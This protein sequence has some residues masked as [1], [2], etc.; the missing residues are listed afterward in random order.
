MKVAYKIVNRNTG[1]WQRQRMIVT[2][3][4]IAVGDNDILTGLVFKWMFGACEPSWL[5]IQ[6]RVCKGFIPGVYADSESNWT[7]AISTAF[8]KRWPA[9]TPEIAAW[10]RGEFGQ[11]A[12]G[13]IVWDDPKV[14]F[15]HDATLM[16]RP[17][18]ACNQSKV[19]V[20][21]APIPQ[22]AIDGTAISLTWEQARYLDVLIKHGDWMSD[23][24]YRRDHGSENDRPDRWRKALSPIVQTS[25]ET[26][27]KKGS[28]WKMA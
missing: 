22:I 20:D 8:E 28:R 10:V 17:A 9:S 24:E 13:I 16:T 26:D 18:V 12:P 4:W 19:K 21:I 14:E 1:E 3:G 23:S 15:G 5:D 7:M 27:R 6:N 2:G 11:N 25:I